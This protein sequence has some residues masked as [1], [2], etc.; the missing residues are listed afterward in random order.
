MFDHVL[1]ML[2]REPVTI[3]AIPESLCNDVQVSIRDVGSLRRTRR[4]D[5][6]PLTTDLKCQRLMRAGNF[7]LYVHVRVMQLNSDKR[8]E[9]D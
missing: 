8:Q 1:R 9:I 4:T 6:S 5:A 7:G 2:V 3:V